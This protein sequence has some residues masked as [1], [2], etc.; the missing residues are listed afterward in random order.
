MTDKT[1]SSGEA[2]N[3]VDKPFQVTPPQLNLP[4]G[5]GAIRG[6]GEKFAAN[7]VTGTGSMTV[8]IYTSPGRSG[9]GPQLSV[10]YDSGSGNGSFGFGWSLSL[11][12]I[13]RKTDKGLPQY[14]D[15]QESDTFILSSAED[16]V[17]QLVSK[18]GQ[19][20]R[21]VSGPRAVNNRQ[22]MIHRYRPRVEGLFAR[23]ERWSN[24]ADPQDT[25]WRSIT[26]ENVT[27]WY[28]KTAESRVADPA[29]PT[30]IFTWLICESY[31]DKGN[32]A[33]YQY[34]PED[35]SG[36]DLSQA[37]ERNRSDA[38]RSVQR[39]IKH[40]FYGNR[41]A[42]F[43]DLT[44]NPPLELSTDWCFELVFDYGEHDLKNPQPQDTGAP[45][46]VCRLDPFSTYRST[47]E[48]R[49]YRL[50]QRVLMFHHFK[51]E[52]NV[53][54]D[55]VVRSTDFTYSQAPFPDPTQPFYSFLLSVTQTGWARRA[56]DTYLKN[57]LPPIEFEYSQAQVDET[58]REVDADSEKNLPNGID[59]SNYRWVDLD[60]EGLSGILTEQAG[61]W[62]YKSNL[63]PVNQK[64]IDGEQ[65][66]LAKFE[67]V[68][69]VTR[70]P[71]LASLTSG[72]QQLL[73]L[74]GDG[75]LD[76]VDFQGRC[77]GFF[78]RTDDADWQPF[79]PFSSLP[80]LDWRNPNLKFI[81]LTGDGFADLLISED[82]VFWW[83]TSLSTIGFG[84]AQ[85]VSQA[86]DEEKGPRLVF[87]DGTETIFLA[88]CSGDG[89][90]D[91]VRVRN[92]EV[93]Y[94]P[95]L[96][97]GRFGAKVTMD[98]SPLFDRQD[99]FDGRRIR[100]ADID[101]SGTADII[102]FAGREVHLYF[103][104]SGN[105]WG[106]RRALTHFPE[107]ESHSTATPL[108]LLGNGTA[109]LVWS[110]SLPGNARRPMRYI[111][112]MGGQKP[113]LLVL[114]RNNLGAETIV[115]YAPSTK[116]YVMDK[117]A[118]TPWLT[119][120]PFPVQV[121]ERVE[122]YDYI[123]RN[124]FVTSYTYHHGF[125]DGVEREFR[126]FGRV[127]QLD[128]EELTTLTST[129]NFPQPA[130][131]DPSSNVPPILTKTWFHTG[132]FF[133]EGIVSKHFEQEYYAE[134]DSNEAIAGLMPAQLEAMLL[135]DSVLP[136]AI[137][138]P[139]GTRIPYDLSG[140]EMREACR[141]L[142][143][144]ILRQEI[145]AMDG[146]E[147]SDRPYSA[148]ERNYTIEMLQAKN[149][150]QY[151]AFFA[152]PRETIDYH[153]ERKLYKVVGS[154]LADQNHPPLNVT[155]AAD[156]R[157]THAATLAVDPF[158]NV[159]QS[160]SIAYGRRYLDPALTATDQSKQSS[161]LSVY[162]ERSYTNAIVLD[163]RYRAPLGAE[164]ST[165][166]LLQFQPDANQPGLTNLFRFAE[167]QRKIAN[168]SDGAHDIA[169]ENLNP[170]G[171]NSN[172]P[173]RRLVQRIRTYYRPDDMGQAAGDPKAL[174]ALK[175][176]ESLGL[177]GSSYKLA[178]TL[179]L[180]P[181]V[182][183]RGGSPLLPVPATVLGSIGPDGGGYIDLDGDGNWWSQAGRIYYA[184]APAT[185]VQEK[186]QALQHFFLP[187]RYEDPFG[188][189]TTVDFDDPHDLLPVKS[190]DALAGALAN[191]TQV[192]NDYRVLQV[193]LLTDPNGSCAEARFDALGMVVGTAVYQ[194]ALGDSFATFTSDLTQAQIDGFYGANDP[195][196][197]ADGLLGTATTRIVYGVKQFWNTRLAAPN[198]PSKW[199]PAFAATLARE[200]HVSDLSG[201]QTTKI[202]ILF[203]YSDGYGREIQKKVQAEPGPVTDKGPVVNPRWV[204][205]GWTIFNNKG[206]PVRQ[207]EPF[208]SQLPAM[209]HQFEFGVQV[210][211]SPI[212]CYDPVDRVVA[213]INA[214]HSYQKVTFD[215]WHKATWDSND[216]VLQSDPT[217]DSDVGD[218]FQLLPTGEY[219]P[220]WY[221][222]RIGGGLGPQE[223]DAAN[224]AAAHANTPTLAYFDTL[225]RTFLTILDNGGGTTFPSRVEFDIQGNQRAVRD[226]IVQGGDQQGRVVMRYDYDLLQKQIHQASMEAGER[227]S[228]NDCVGKLVRAWD[229]RGHNL[230]SEYDPLRRPTRLFVLGT[231][232][233]NSD[234]RTTAG[235]VLVDQS[236]YGE[237][238][239]AALNARTHVFQHADAAG[240]TTN[241]GTNP[242]S[243]LD[244]AFDFKGNLLRSGRGFFADYVALPNLTA[245]PPTPDVFAMSTRY[246]ALNRP[247]ALTTPD[248]SVIQSTYN[249]ANLLETVS[250]NLRG[251][252]AATPFV[253]NIDYD[254]KGQRIL[255]VLGS[256]NTQTNYTYDPLT[257]RL[258]NLTT[259][260]PSDSVALQDLSY[261]YDPVGNVTHI[262]D[263][264]DIH[265][266]VFF[267]N[268]RVE[269]SADYTYDAI[270]R[271][272]QAS[273]REQLGLGALPPEPTSYNDVP[274]ANLPHPGDGN[275]MGTYTEKYQ[276]DG[277]GNS[278]QFVHQGM[279][280]ANPGWTRVYSYNEISLLEAGKTNNR[281][282]STAI[283]GSQ[284]LNEP[285]TYDQHGSMASMPQLHAME[286]DFKEELLM[287]QRQAV[288]GNDQDGQKH[289]GERTYYLYDGTGQRARK[290]TQSAAGTKIKER[291]YLGGFELYREYDGA[292]NVTL[293]RE[294]L[295][296]MDDQE[297]VA[298]VETK[299]VDSSAPLGSL[300]VTTTRYQFGNHLGTAC[301]ELDENADVIT[302]EEYYPYGS[303][304]Y[305]AG[306]T[307][308][309]VS[310]KRYRYIGKERDLETGFYYC[311]TRYYAPWLGRWI[312]TDP[313]GIAGGI[314]L[315]GYSR[316]NPVVLRDPGG[317]DPDTPVV[318]KQENLTLDIPDLFIVKRY[319]P[320]PPPPPPKNAGSN[321]GLQNLTNGNPPSGFAA[322]GHFQ[323]E[324]DVGGALTLTLPNGGKLTGT[325][326]SSIIV[327]RRLGLFQ[328]EHGRGGEVGVYASSSLS[329]PAPAIVQGTLH[330]GDDIFGLYLQLGRQ[331]DA[332]GK[333]LGTAWSV[334][335]SQAATSQD[336][337]RQL[338]VNESVVHLPSSQVGGK[339][340]TDATSGTLLVGVVFDPL[341]KK[342]ESTESSSSSS[343]GQLEDKGVT[344]SA[345]SS[346]KD[347]LEPGPTA[348]GGEIA[349]SIN[350]G[351]LTDGGQGR[352]Y[353]G[354]ALLFITHA[355]DN[356]QG[357]FGFALGASYETGGGGVTAFLRFGIAF[358]K[359]TKAGEVIPFL[360]PLVPP[361]FH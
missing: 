60:G 78:E 56:P 85:R 52:G 279:N 109:C 301:L 58:V 289:Q 228:L 128:T 254:A 345:S 160:A 206:K 311:S 157:V 239:P 340:V 87:A 351:K 210:G 256:A 4:K 327:A 297:R 287:T 19:W 303:T 347:D 69:L 153:Y 249:E 66:T 9:F 257:F 74:S 100:L 322:P 286:W 39:Y 42:Y 313:K 119:R 73:D 40:I 240:M 121:V 178:F 67:P 120:L 235:E 41:T 216:T 285:Y 308:A 86:F 62:F 132:A 348:F 217:T 148:S 154:T 177:P 202:Q 30:R 2:R 63:S 191:V 219:F 77:P 237:G 204:G 223:Q 259:T 84:P 201:G 247:I 359:S 81:D 277:V 34:K 176:V 3:A 24:V 94:W 350:T 315:Y 114:V 208:F 93:C 354:T 106:P 185:S 170:S 98:Q 166:E 264:A 361:P 117:L 150:N 349:G 203:S 43:P 125:Y 196:T 70:Q 319:I 48:V 80:V 144:S 129:S 352:S 357:I 82:Q 207:F 265:N 253:T 281:L 107:V 276:Y 316:E 337:S 272:I 12:H 310:L 6:I 321:A 31:D 266:V 115:Q 152:H 293:A 320:P 147:A 135:D 331:S 284:V 333:T 21:D 294:T 231:D 211:V 275:A 295:Q 241:K 194:G 155:N 283:S 184:P 141:A 61:S 233:A 163:D 355:F 236:I 278:L 22:Y 118:G 36:V 111:D 97:Y 224:R 158:G 13:T 296:V 126:G 101:G 11:P 75:K 188:N 23:I 92:G 179:G 329:L 238:Q 172:Q 50:C 142:R 353:T 290:T 341:V 91:L 325:G 356:K 183:Q 5:G 33:V 65:V 280:P 159:L 25:F 205:A 213:T 193:R 83:H 169:Y 343:S 105:A 342:E 318:Q 307:L 102:Y 71:S 246:D 215:P 88:D 55:C 136:T 242:V 332:S 220:T 339:D 305:Q 344:A 99:S 161:T 26:K 186:S 197:L 174:L 291:F 130:N 258:M 244:E 261:T 262:Q 134:G 222:Q 334:L 250:V 76:L 103:N 133:G 72:T 180:I 274:R 199:L 140:E 300:P 90:T 323:D 346:R 124:R 165:Y 104:Q 143:G 212:L 336:Q 171:L 267:R 282:S 302:Y 47:F 32:V 330:L 182:Y 44:V 167:L 230:R 162:S 137:L 113:H 127:D 299:T 288:N 198:D 145:Y 68:G 164:A 110:S 122:S 248:Q 338:Y 192:T 79:Q 229:T 17:P 46:W 268:V 151:G 96:G 232:A 18:G 335:E 108:D 59:G 35:F 29:D 20:V 234:P 209:V 226:A 27:T 131:Q 175:T 326:S 270:Y 156:P 138:Q 360:E 221:T 123:S 16:L 292:G 252:A 255:I 146:T 89:L 214:N 271:L 112:L 168:A 298:L 181:L 139:D 260:R 1:Q 243:G 306:R 218:F 149:P 269:P 227:W 28:G 358:D 187:R 312:S 45:A 8:P 14:V 328:G 38:T 251:A 53:G 57:S 263:D 317:Q 225:G 314:N 7:P 304:S 189:L 200:A 309:E 51:D 95:N 116:F 15:A 273:G 37:N 190:T 245:P 49:T 64:T 195:H 173:Y 54:S 324:V 10:S